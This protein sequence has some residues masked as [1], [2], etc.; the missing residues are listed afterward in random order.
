M[1]KIG[2]PLSYRLVQGAIGKRFVI[3]H[4]AYG[5]IQTKFPDMTHIIA[6]TLQVDCRNLFKEAV[7]YA[8]SVIADPI[9][10]AEWQKRIKRRRHSHRVA[11]HI[12][13]HFHAGTVKL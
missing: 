12:L 5:I 1:K 4:Y 3:K 9:K 13:T 6:S 8:Q 10:K 7:K 11:F 2:L